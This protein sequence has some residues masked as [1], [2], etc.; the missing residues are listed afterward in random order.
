MPNAVVKAYAKQTGKSVEHVERWWKEAEVEAAK[1]F[2]KKDDSYWAYVNGI[3]ERR[4]KLKHG[5]RK[6]KHVKEGG[7]LTFKQFVS[8]SDSTD[9]ETLIDEFVSYAI[10]NDLNEIAR[11]YDDPFDGAYYLMGEMQDWLENEKGFSADEAEA[12]AD[13]HR[14]QA[15]EHFQA[16]LT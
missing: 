8:E 4:G 1:K 14:D 3:V 16:G 12:W 9:P 13:E 11:G 10:K 7:K 5:K 15:E 2:D 6:R